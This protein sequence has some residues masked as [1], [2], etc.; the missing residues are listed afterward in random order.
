MALFLPHFMPQFR[1][2]P[3][4]LA[5]ASAA[6]SSCDR[7][8]P[9]SATAVPA[10]VCGPGGACDADVAPGLRAAAA[11]IGWADLAADAPGAR[12]EVRVWMTERPAEAGRVVRVV[13]E[14]ASAVGEA[15]SW[16]PA[17][18]RDSVEV[19]DGTGA[20][21]RLVATCPA[22]VRR[23]GLTVCRGPRRGA[24]YAANLR[25]L[26]DSLG[27]S[28]LPGDSAPGDTLHVH[29]WRVGPSA[30][31]IETRDAAGR[32]RTVGYNSRARGR[33][34]PPA[35]VERVWLLLSQWE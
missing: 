31:V 15:A 30:L 33:A 11:A 23:G 22:A 5:A 14:G 24:P 29:R 17:G 20:P 8:A 16:W 2:L 35:E 28:S 6:S 13:G 18:E 27:V 34:A 12:S 1:A 4:L 9:A 26:L 3:L 32:Y 19:T 21:P 10:P 25:R 7:G